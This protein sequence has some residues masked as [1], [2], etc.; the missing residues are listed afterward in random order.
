IKLFLSVILGPDRQVKDKS[1]A[2]ADPALRP[3]HAPMTLHN[4][5]ADWKPQPCTPRLVCEGVPHLFKLFEN[6]ILFFRRYT[7]A[8]VDYPYLD[9]VS[10]IRAHWNM[11]G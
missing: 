10:A 11:E 7:D 8:G 1:A 3:Y 5:F 4:L 2:L 9:S 6:L